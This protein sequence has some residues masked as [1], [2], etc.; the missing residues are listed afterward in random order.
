[1]DEHPEKVGVDESALGIDD[2]GP[3]GSTG[4]PSNSNS[5]SGSGGRNCTGCLYYGGISWRRKR[6][7]GGNRLQVNHGNSQQ[8]KVAEDGR[9]WQKVALLSEEA[10]ASGERTGS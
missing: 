5:S 2:S 6:V 10:L 8:Q 7:R 1:M 9:R 3:T 4:N